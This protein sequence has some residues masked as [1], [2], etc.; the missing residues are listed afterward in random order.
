VKN[1]QK[2]DA[3]YLKFKIFMLRNGIK[4]KEIAKL[5]NK[6]LSSFNQKLNGTSGDFSASEVRTI[7]KKYNISSDEY[8]VDQKVSNM[9]P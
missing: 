4:Q 3:S 2:K 1:K 6:S 7:C 9:K 8:F 5:L